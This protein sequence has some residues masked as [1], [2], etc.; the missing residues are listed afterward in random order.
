MSSGKVGN[1]D[2][3]LGLAVAAAISLLLIGRRLRRRRLPLS[4]KTIF[5]TGCDSGY[6]FSLAIHARERGMRVMAACYLTEG[7]GRCLLENLGITVVDLDLTRQESIAAAAQVVSQNCSS[8]GKTKAQ[9]L[10]FRNFALYLDHK[11][12]ICTLRTPFNIT[13]LIIKCGSTHFACSSSSLG[14]K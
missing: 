14:K 2:L 8:S 7:E 10:R 4:G 5:I 3:L 1:W 12:G 9:I 11:C 6:G 13:F